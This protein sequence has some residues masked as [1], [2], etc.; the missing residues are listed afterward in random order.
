VRALDSFFA[1]AVA[2]RAGVW[3]NDTPTPALAAV[4]PHRHEQVPDGFLRARRSF[5]KSIMLPPGIPFNTIRTE[6]F[7]Q[8]FFK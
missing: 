1:A 4:V 3:D 7:S 8:R 5:E 2:R 6:L